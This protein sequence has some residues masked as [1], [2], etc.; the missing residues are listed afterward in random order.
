LAACGL[1]VSAGAYGDNLDTA[2]V[3]EV[4]D[5]KLAGFIHNLNPDLTISPASCP[6]RVDVSNGKRAF[7]TVVVNGERLPVSVTYGGPPQQ[8]IVAKNASLYWMDGIERVAQAMLSSQLGANVGISCG[9]PRFRLLDV[10]SIF[11]CAVQHSPTVKSVRLK[12]MP[13]AQVFIFSPAAFATPSWMKEAVRRHK[14]G[15]AVSLDGPTV[16]DWLQS[17]AAA[18]AAGIEVSPKPTVVITCPSS[19]NV[20]G[21]RH[22]L[23]IERIGDQTMRLSI[24]IDEPV[25]VHARSLGVLVDR[26]KV[27]RLAQVDINAQL[28]QNG[29]PPDFVVRCGRGFFVV[30]PP[31]TFRC[32]ATNDNKAYKLEVQVEEGT[33]RWSA[34]PLEESPSPDPAAT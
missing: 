28:Q 24:S 4:I 10:G 22:E 26:A 31:A 21:T 20:S 30:T 25:G 3:K 27:Q 14:A 23:C 18:E 17:A 5:T 29:S 7:C 19:L 16:A 9:S 8:F 33:M 15:L 6:D 2:A 12:A 34:V 13:N 32:D 11:T 1:G